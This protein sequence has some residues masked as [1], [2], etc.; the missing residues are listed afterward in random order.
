MGLVTLPSNP[1]GLRDGMDANKGSV[2]LANDQAIIA[3]VNGNLADVNIATGAAINGSK[4][5]Q[6]AGLRVPTDAIEDDA[7]TAAKLRDDGAVDGNRA[8]TTDHIRDA[9]ITSAK[10]GALA[11]LLSKVKT[12][13]FDWTPGGTIP[14]ASAIF[15]NTGIT[16]ATGTPLCCE[17]RYAAAPSGA[18]AEIVVLKFWLNTATGQYWLVAGNAAL[19]GVNIAAVTFRA[20]FIAAS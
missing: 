3:Q 11:V 1:V 18:A 17:V 12:T 4:L 6:T 20:T 15:T 5:A 7:I 13:T 19:G 8:V 2:V 16:S 10:L 14:G 9:A